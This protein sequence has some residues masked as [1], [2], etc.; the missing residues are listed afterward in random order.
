MKLV[1]IGGGHAAAQLVTSANIKKLG[2]EITLISDEPVLP[3]QRPPL[4][5]AYLL[6]EMDAAR[7]PITTEKTYEK[8]NCTPHLGVKAESINRADKTVTTSD[9]QNHTY[10]KLVLAT[11]GRARPL[12][13]E[14]ADLKGVH[15]VRTLA[16]IDALEHRIKAGNHMVIIGG[17][18]IGLEAA[19]V[20]RKKEMNVTLLEA[21][22]RILGRVVSP[23]VS[24]FYTKI[25]TEEQVKILT[26]TTAS[27]II[28]EQGSVKAVQ[29]TDGTEYPADIVIVGIGILPNQEI[30]EK[31]ELETSNGIKVNDYCQT[32]DPDIYAVGDVA[33]HK[34]ALYGT[35]LRVESVQNAVDQS[36]LVIDHIMGNAS[37]Y[38]ALPWFWSDQ[39]D[40]KL[41]IAGLSIDYD[42]VVTRKEA[43]RKISFFYMKEDTLVAC[44][45]VNDMRSFMAAKK[46]IAN[47]IPVDDAKLADLTVTLKD[48]IV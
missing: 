14:G 38:D 25:H 43:D 3:Y 5:K 48:L 34:S 33:L 46:L 35:E 13:V 30:A 11:G 20:A 39:Y 37:P 31:A 44:D 42:R 47:K 28:G 40:M 18:Y 15:A 6:G 21:S 27:K 22:D 45:A 36:K 41:Q 1:I 19:A 26:E 29:L 32:N 8:A 23:E 9:G 16:D 7:L 4:S 2:A 10:D 17:G 12:P 24:E